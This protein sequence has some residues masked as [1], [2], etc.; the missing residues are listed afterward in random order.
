MRQKVWRVWIKLHIIFDVANHIITSVKVM[1]EHE[2]D[3]KQFNELVKDARDNVGKIGKIYGDT[4]Y[5]SRA[6]F[7]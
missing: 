6:N 1:T 2:A 4:A 5:D 7:N 3:S